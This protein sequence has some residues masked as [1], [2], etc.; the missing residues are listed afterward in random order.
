MKEEFETKLIELGISFQ[1][2]PDNFYILSTINGVERKITVRL[3]C[4]KLVNP[5]KYG[6]NNGNE[7]ESI[8]LFKLQFNPWRNESDFITFAFLN[9]IKHQIEYII[10]PTELL[11]H[12]L[13]NGTRIRS[14]NHLFIIVFWLMPDGFVYNCS[15]IGIEGEWYYL[16]KGVN[17]RMADDTELDYTSFLNKWEILW[18][19]KSSL[20]TIE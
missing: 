5:L 3:I 9:S 1:V 16:S 15:D 10:V 17:G 8:G 4:S 2:K 6:S 14:E 13:I 7:I 20:P 11:K 18:K 12:R 19:L